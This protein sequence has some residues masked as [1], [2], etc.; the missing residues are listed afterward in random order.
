M[1]K[2]VRAPIV[3]VAAALAGCTYTEDRDGLFSLEEARE[4]PGS[5]PYFVGQ[6]FEGLQLNRILGPYQPITFI[7]GECGS[8]PTEDGT[9]PSPLHILVYP[10]KGMVP[11]ASSPRPCRKVT[12]RGVEGAFFGKTIGRDLTLELYVGDRAVT[13]AAD[14]TARALRAAAALRPVDA[15][16][17]SAGDLPLPTQD[18]TAGLARC[19]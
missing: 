11:D 17:A 19:S 2:R 5:P 3:L 7:Y 15:D 10:L 18:V 14:S 16:G 8:P 12:V 1:P 4:L 13:I 9:C 6:S